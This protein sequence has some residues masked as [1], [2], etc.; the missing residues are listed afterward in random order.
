MLPPL[1][2][3]I[4]LLD[5]G[6]VIRLI[7]L[8]RPRPRCICVLLVSQHC[9]REP[10]VETSQLAT[11][12]SFKTANLCLTLAHATFPP[13]TSSLDIYTSSHS[14]LL[15][16]RLISSR[17]VALHA[18]PASHSSS[19]ALMSVSDTACKPASRAAQA[20]SGNQV[21]VCSE[22]LYASCYTKYTVA[23]GI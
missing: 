6:R 11:L 19:R 18:S 16:L 7:A 8:V 21:R 14:F 15:H 12:A 20:C 23:S 1:P 5:A 10:A 2:P 22:Q 17:P 3:P 9:L 4:A 13:Y